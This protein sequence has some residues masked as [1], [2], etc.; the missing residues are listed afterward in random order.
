MISHG[1]FSSF[2]SF[3]PI[4]VLVEKFVSLFCALY[5]FIMSLPAR[6]TNKTSLNYFGSQGII[7]NI[8]C[9]NTAYDTFSGNILFE[10]SDHF[11]QFV[12]L[13]K[14][15]IDYKTFS[16]GKR[17]YLKFYGQKCI[18]DF[19]R[20]SM[21]FLDDPSLSLNCKFEKFYQTL[22]SCVDQHVPTKK[23]TKMTL[24]F[25]LSLGND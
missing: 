3:M 15:D 11:P 22:S 5:G 9:N 20:K 7:D 23:M 24:N 4:L 25:I 2:S 12:V 6:T 16:D 13:N 14:S 8:F 17:D 10:I 21:A 1:A 19:S 18:S